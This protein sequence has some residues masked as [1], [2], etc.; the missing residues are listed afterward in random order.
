MNEEVILLLLY[1]RFVC[2]MISGVWNTEK[3]AGYSF[4]SETKWVDIIK[5][6]S[7]FHLTKHDIRN[8]I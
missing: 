2:S 7:D 4:Q 1:T 5:L 3:N 8:W 6:E